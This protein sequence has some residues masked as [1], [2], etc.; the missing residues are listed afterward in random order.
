MTTWTVWYGILLQ[1]KSSIFAEVVSDV[2]IRSLAER[3]STP[4][5]TMAFLV[6]AVDRAVTEAIPGSGSPFL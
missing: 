1:T 4:G 6:T 2:V 5:A 3:E